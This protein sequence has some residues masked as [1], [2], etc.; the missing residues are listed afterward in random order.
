MK[1]LRRAKTAPDRLFRCN[2]FKETLTLARPA[3]LAYLMFAAPLALAAPALAQK[4]KLLFAITTPMLCE[5]D[6]DAIGH[7]Y[8]LRVAGARPPLKFRCPATG[9]TFHSGASAA[10]SHAAHSV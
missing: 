2:Q 7:D 10:P 4:T 9:E 6:L 5:A 8:F 3:K 1:E